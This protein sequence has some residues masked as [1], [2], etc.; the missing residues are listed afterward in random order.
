V[1]PDLYKFLNVE[2]KDTP[3]GEAAEAVRSRLKVPMIVDHAALTKQKIDFET[4]K[5]SLPKTNTFYGKILERLLYAAKL[6][7]E[8]RTDEADQP[9]LWITTLRP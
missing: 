3:V 9:F 1:L 4:T 8:L 6:K 7:Y 2:V 5:V